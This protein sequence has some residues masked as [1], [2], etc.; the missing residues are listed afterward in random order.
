MLR[1]MCRAKIH[2]A[3]I[4]GTVLHYEGSISIAK[5]ILAASGMLPGEMVQV[6]NVNTGN[7]FETYVIEGRNN[8]GISLNGGAARLGEVGDPLI[9][10]SYVLV[11]EKEAKGFK[12]KVV[13]L[14]ESNRIVKTR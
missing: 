14:D 5:E 4:S 9:I 8:S 6:I 3:R 7:R 10:L 12:P 13:S 1:F 2:K 11:D